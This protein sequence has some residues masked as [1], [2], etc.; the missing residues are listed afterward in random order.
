MFTGEFVGVAAPDVPTTCLSPF[1][2]TYIFC[3]GSGPFWHSENGSPHVGHS[4]H[5]LGDAGNLRF[6]FD[7]IGF[8]PFNGVVIVFP[9]AS[10][11]G[12]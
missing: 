1:E 7:L 12:T 5:S 4:D 10:R 11:M 3:P 2:W 8:V 9:P 6:W